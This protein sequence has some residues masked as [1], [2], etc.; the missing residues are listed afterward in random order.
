MSKRVE[1][2]YFPE[3]SAK[4]KFW[5]YVTLCFILV[6]VMTAG[7]IARSVILL[8]TGFLAYV[9]LTYAYLEE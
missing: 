2:K 7:F 6:G 1:E 5:A 4:Q 8:F 9:F 3:P